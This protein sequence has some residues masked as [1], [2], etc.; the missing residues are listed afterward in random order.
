MKPILD[1]CCGGKMFYANKNNPNVL[2]CDKREFET[3]FKKSKQKDEYFIVKPDVIADFRDLLFENE[4]FSLVIFDPP[5]IKNRSD[6]SFMVQKYGKLDKS[7]KEDLSKGFKECMR[8][9][10]NNGTLIFKWSEAQISL[11]EILSC[12]DKEPLLMQ[13]TS[14]TSHFCVFFKERV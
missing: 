12:F 4:S 1:V 14:R 8:V 3:I 2:F 6:K 7:Y 10:K 13:K 11:S 9:L 5:H